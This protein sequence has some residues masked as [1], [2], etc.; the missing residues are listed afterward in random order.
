V[1]EFNSLVSDIQKLS[2]A[3]GRME[4]VLKFLS[5]VEQRKSREVA[6]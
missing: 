1:K 4:E 5:C 2:E 3:V 6:E